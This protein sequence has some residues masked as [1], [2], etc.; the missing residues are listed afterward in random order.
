MENFL[1]E[2]F[3]VFVEAT[4][5]ENFYLRDNLQ[6]PYITNTLSKKKIQESLI[7]FT[8]EF[9][10]KNS[11]K[12]STPGPVYK[13]AFMDKEKKFIYDLFELTEEKVLELS[14][15]NGYLERKSEIFELFSITI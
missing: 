13:I 10:D 12:L 2:E 11:A 7:E 14:K 6:I 15:N 3:S 4:Y 9:I 5:K 8:G 1:E